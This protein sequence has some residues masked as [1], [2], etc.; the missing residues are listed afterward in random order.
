MRSQRP[1]SATAAAILAIVYGSLFT[2]CGL[3]GAASLV[4]Q[5]GM[6]KNLMGGADPN[7]AEIQKQLDDTLKRDI[8]GYQAFQ[9]GG[10]IVGLGE[11]LALLLAGIGLL[12]MQPWARTLALVGSLVAMVTTALQA[13]Y[14]I[15]FVMPAMNNAFQGILPAAMAKQAG[16]PGGPAPR[17][18]LNVMQTMMTVIAVVSVI[19][20]VLIIIYLIILVMLLRRRHVRA[21]FAGQPGDDYEGGPGRR[22]GRDGEDEDEAWNEPRRPDEPR[23]EHYR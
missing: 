19:V 3:C 5:G 11:A 13:A 22:E 16:G 7:Q 1:G 14:Q 10:T 2:L 18:V 4:M 23:D 17:E 20:Y 21:A 8:P 6:G 15:A 9:V 12:N